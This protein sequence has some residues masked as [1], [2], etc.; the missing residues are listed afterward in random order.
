MALKLFLEFVDHGLLHAVVPRL[1]VRGLVGCAEGQRRTRAQVECRRPHQ[2][3]ESALFNIHRL[4]SP[5]KTRNKNSLMT[6]RSLWWAG[7][8][9]L[10]S[11]RGPRTLSPALGKPTSALRI[12]KSFR[13][14][15]K[16]IQRQLAQVSAC[17]RSALVS[18]SEID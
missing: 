16:K 1:V 10:V 5:Q 15:A 12:R 3:A 6:G 4:S 7:P 14:Q 9:V 11:P 18:T 13:P 8:G 17:N 2:P